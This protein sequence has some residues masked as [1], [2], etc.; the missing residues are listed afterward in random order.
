MFSYSGMAPNGRP[1][2]SPESVHSGPHQFLIRCTRQEHMSETY[3]SPLP[4]SL[5]PGRTLNGAIEKQGL[6]HV[7]P[8]ASTADPQK[9]FLSIVAGQ[10]RDT[11]HAPDIATC[12]RKKKVVPWSPSRMLVA[13]FCSFQAPRTNQLSRKHAKNPLIG[14]LMGHRRRCTI[15][16]QQGPQKL[17]HARH[18]D[19]ETG[20]QDPC[21]KF[22]V[23]HDF[24]AQK[25]LLGP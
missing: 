22:S 6:G 3:F 12:I 20:N 24:P 23:P 4:L 14:G 5:T 17:P 21:C 18:M 16:E 9:F 2:P 15:V 7:V 13:F 10:C 11:R 25:F 8:R 19:L 1:P